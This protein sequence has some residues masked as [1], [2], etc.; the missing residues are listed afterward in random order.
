M[1]ALSTEAIVNRLNSPDLE[2]RLVVSP[3]LDVAGQAKP[4]QSSIDVR[5][6][7]D[8]CLVTASSIGAISEFDGLTQPRLL[9]ELYRRH[10]VPFGRSLVI[11]PH[12]FMLAQTLEYLRLPADLMAY[13]VGRSTWG[14]LGLIVATAVGIHPGFAGS[15]TL[16][17][18]NLGEAPITLYPGQTIAQL[19]FHQ[20]IDQNGNPSKTAAKNTQYVGTVDMVPQRLSSELTHNVLEKLVRKH[21]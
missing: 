9:K 1:S 11:H 14:R 18:R 5:L 15:L 19:F 13:V 4:G 10:Y 16:E 2:T 6:G 3:L 21:R 20:V 12:Q 8:F 7:F 17:L